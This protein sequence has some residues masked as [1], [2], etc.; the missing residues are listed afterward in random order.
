MNEE[1]EQSADLDNKG[2]GLEK[3]PLGIDDGEVSKSFELENHEI[4]FLRALGEFATTPRATKRLVNL[5]ILLRVQTATKGLNEVAIF[6]DKERGE[7]RAAA[8]LL[9]LVVEKRA[10]LER[11]ADKFDVNMLAQML[12]NNLMESLKGAVEAR[13]DLDILQEQH[14]KLPDWQ[15]FEKWLLEIRRFS[16]PWKKWTRSLKLEST[17]SV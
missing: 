16:F 11:F 17:F 8:L 9:A 4:E 10:L 2:E 12:S 14:G 13:L 7:Y 3:D 1:V 6:A 5:Y 15:S